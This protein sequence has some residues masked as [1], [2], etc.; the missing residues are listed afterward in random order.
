MRVIFVETTRPVKM[1]PR[2]ETSPVN[3]HFLS[4]GR[5]TDTEVCI[6]DQNQ[7]I[8]RTDVRAVNCLRGGLESKTNILVPP[9]LLSGDL[10]AAYIHPR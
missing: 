8:G 5:E 2:M 3:G 7:G 9:L 10:L 6:Y 4:S 1:R